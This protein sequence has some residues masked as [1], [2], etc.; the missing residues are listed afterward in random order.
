MDNTRG[1]GLL[2]AITVKRGDRVAQLIIEKISTPEVVEVD[3]SVCVC[4]MHVPY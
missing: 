3:V 2:I 4:A 1:I